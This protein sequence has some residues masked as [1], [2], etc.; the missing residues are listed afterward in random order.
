MPMGPGWTPTRQHIHKS[1]STAGGLSMAW[2]KEVPVAGAHGEEAGLK[3]LA[4]KSLQIRWVIILPHLQVL[5]KNARQPS[6]RQTHTGESSKT[7]PPGGTTTKM[8]RPLIHHRPFQ[9][10][11]DCVENPAPQTQNLNPR[12]GVLHPSQSA[13]WKSARQ[14][15][16]ITTRGT[17]AQVAAMPRRRRRTSGAR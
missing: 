10:L 14:N 13:S 4:R 2:R 1:C 11:Q 15:E 6:P 17:P 3:K 12:K 5:E 9:K 8:P 16:M 7:R